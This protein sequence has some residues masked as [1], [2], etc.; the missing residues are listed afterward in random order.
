MFAN[1]RQKHIHSLIKQ[2][3]AVTTAELTA[4][5]GVSIETIRKDLLAMERDNL[6]QRVHGGAISNKEMPLF[7][8][9]SARIEEH[10]DL[11]RMLSRAAT[12]LISENDIIGV[13]AGSTAVIFAEALKASF[14]QL[15]VITQSMDVLEILNGYKGFKVIL[16]GG[17]YNAEERAFYGPVTINTMQ[18]L[19]MQKAFIFPSAVSLK[20]GIADFQEEMFA[21]QKQF[22]ES[23]DNIFILADSSK[24]EQTALMKLDDMRTSYTY[25]TDHELPGNLKK[26]YRENNITIITE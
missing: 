12:G 11:K 25:V 9:L 21:V 8:S 6:L 22:L 17:L 5:F 20:H 24:F 4:Q 7:H 2:N 26:L 1:E 13:D 15:T 23:A 18:N 19:H 14:S 10:V 3:G 16:C